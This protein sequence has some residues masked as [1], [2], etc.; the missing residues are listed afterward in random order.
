MDMCAMFTLL[1]DVKNSI[2]LNQARKCKVN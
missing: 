2:D 1:Q